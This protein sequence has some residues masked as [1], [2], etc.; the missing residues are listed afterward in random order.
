MLTIVLNN[1]VL[2]MGKLKLKKREHEG[3]MKVSASSMLYNRGLLSGFPAICIMVK[4]KG[5]GRD[6]Y[7]RSWNGS[8]GSITFLFQSTKRSD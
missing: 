7:V 3:W 2:D 4:V 8:N 1:R 6:R 5:G